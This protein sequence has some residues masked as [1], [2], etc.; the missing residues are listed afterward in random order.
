VFRSE[1]LI[2]LRDSWFSAKPVLAGRLLVNFFG[3]EHYFSSGDQMILPTYFKLRIQ[4]RKKAVE[5]K[6]IRSYVK[7]ETAQI[8]E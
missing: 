3:V 8:V 5:L 6:V 1:K 7:R 2:E 4:K